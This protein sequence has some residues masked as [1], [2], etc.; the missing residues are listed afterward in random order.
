V[1]LWKQYEDAERS[2][3]VGWAVIAGHIVLYLAWSILA[4][5][6]GVYPIALWMGWIE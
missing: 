4:L 6:F 1:S 5:V 3:G 2:G